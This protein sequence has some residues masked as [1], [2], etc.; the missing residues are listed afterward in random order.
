MC[1]N[2]SMVHVE[3]RLLTVLRQWVEN[4]PFHPSFYLHLLSLFC[5]LF[6]LIYIVHSH[7]LVLKALLFLL[8]FYTD[9]NMQC[10]KQMLQ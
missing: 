5:I 4:E 7:I 6:Y 3:A 9:N 8:L 2:D 1:V 10:S